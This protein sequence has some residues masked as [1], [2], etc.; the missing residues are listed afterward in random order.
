MKKHRLLSAVS[1]AALTLTLAGAP[2]LAQEDQLRA[3]AAVTLV[4]LGIDASA[5]TLT[6]DQLAQVEAVASSTDSDEIKA[7]RIREII[8][9]EG[10]AA[11]AGQG[12]TDRQAR[13]SAMSVMASLGISAPVDQLTI[14]H[15]LE[16][17][18]IGNS[19][20]SDESKRDRVEAVLREAGL[21]A[22]G[23]EA[24]VVGQDLTDQQARD[25]A[26]S[27]MATL[28]ISAPVDDLS[29]DQHLQ[30]QAVGS[31]T[32]SD[33]IKAGRIETI[34]R[35]AGLVRAGETGEDSN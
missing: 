4:E 22:R 32:D 28:G 6:P 8:G 25:S 23:G 7:D 20:E 26:M 34:L 35:E 11:V 9:N 21:I 2:A 30:I 16:I 3:S 10:G 5:D 14:E 27:V 29:T 18:S 1:A 15:Q 31:S 33:E 12:L 17:Q 13:D 19:A 24:E